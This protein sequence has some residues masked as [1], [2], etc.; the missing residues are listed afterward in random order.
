MAV[1][2]R[3]A[4]IAGTE[5]RRVFAASRP[6]VGAITR[7]GDAETR[8]ECPN[9]RAFQNSQRNC[10][11]LTGRESSNQNKWLPRNAV[12]QL[13][14]SRFLNVPGGPAWIRTHSVRSAISHPFK[15][16]T[17]NIR[18]GMNVWTQ[19]E[20]VHATGNQVPSPPGAGHDRVSLRRLAGLLAGR[21]GPRPPVLPGDG[22]EGQTRIVMSL[23]ESCSASARRL[24]AN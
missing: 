5:N 15:D 1:K 9:W 6:S 3:G 17:V 24:E 23:H 22:R 16:L 11:E 19:R 20:G 18:R 12:L 7:S 4:Q 21:L 13:F 2:Q 8:R 14:L 10:R